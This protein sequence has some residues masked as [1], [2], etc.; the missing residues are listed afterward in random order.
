MRER[1]T[2]GEKKTNER[3]KTV[4][5]EIGWFVQRHGE[6]DVV[7]WHG[8]IKAID[9]ANSGAENV[10]VGRVDAYAVPNRLI[11]AGPAPWEHL[12]TLDDE[13]ARIAAEV[14]TSFELSDEFAG[15]DETLIGWEDLKASC[16]LMIL[17]FIDWEPSVKDQDI[18]DIVLR[19][20]ALINSNVAMFAV[21]LD[22][23]VADEWRKYGFYEIA[24]KV[25]LSAAQPFR[26]VMSADNFGN[27]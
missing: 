15:A 27:A 16:D 20:L 13:L 24:E 5:P 2:T 6:I 9:S 4:L 14:L 21:V 7:E 26:Q 18:R 8:A 10:E 19:D 1:R 25:Y 23:E 11:N 17:S 22:R 12:D 3:R